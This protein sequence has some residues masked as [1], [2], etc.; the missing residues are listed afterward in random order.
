MNI[1]AIGTLN[2]LFLRGSYTQLNF[3]KKKTKKMK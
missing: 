3:Q 2:Q 1:L